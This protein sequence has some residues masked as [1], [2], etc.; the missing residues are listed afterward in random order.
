[1]LRPRGAAI[2]VSMLVTVL[3]SLAVPDYSLNWIALVWKPFVLPLLIALPL[4]IAVF[5]KPPVLAFGVAISFCAVCLLAHIAISGVVFWCRAGGA[6]FDG[7][8]IPI[9]ALTLAASAIIA[10]VAFVVTW[11]FF[12]RKSLHAG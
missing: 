5:R 9:F 8:S 2:A 10:G 11:A 6:L 3:G 1:M 12:R 7:L 4:A